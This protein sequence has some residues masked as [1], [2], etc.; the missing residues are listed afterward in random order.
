MRCANCS[1][2]LDAKPTLGCCSFTCASRLR[3]DV[4]GLYFGDDWPGFYD[5]LLEELMDF[6]DNLTKPPNSASVGPSGITKITYE[7]EEE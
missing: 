5:E 4:G 6:R 1:K 2:V 3:Q 7:E